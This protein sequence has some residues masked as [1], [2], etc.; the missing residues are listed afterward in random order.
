M[1]KRSRVAVGFA[2]LASVAVGCQLVASIED[3]HY[4]PSDAQ[5]AETLAEVG[6]TSDSSVLDTADSSTVDS[7]DSTSPDTADTKDTTVTDTGDT[8][9]TETATP[10]DTGPAPCPSKA[11]TTAMVRVP[12]AKSSFCM[13]V[14]EVTV[15]QMEVYDG[16]TPT[17]PAGLPARCTGKWDNYYKRDLGALPTEPAINA[18]WCQAFAYCKWAGKRLC[19]ALDTA[20]ALSTEN[21]ELYYACG[22]GA[23]ATARPYGTSYVAGNCDVE[24]GRS[25]PTSILATPKC[26]GPTAPYDKIFNLIGS[27]EEW[28]E[29][30]TDSPAPSKCRARGGYF[31]NIS[32]VAV[33]ARTVDYDITSQFASLGFRCCAD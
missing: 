27:A 31:G 26:H 21:S 3:V 9:P 5:T 4:D 12:T 14:N 25:I 29:E 22:N 13:D 2:A 18:N 28:S 16:A 33:C 8:G 24:T 19:R 6:D 7:G 11:G 1:V 20:A 23:A 15:A 10:P 17:V 32:N 30:C